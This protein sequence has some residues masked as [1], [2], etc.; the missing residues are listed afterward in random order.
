MIG[1]LWPEQHHSGYMHIF[2]PV[3]MRLQLQTVAGPPED[4]TVTCGGVG[5]GGLDD[6]SNH[7]ING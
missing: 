6:H 2:S 3:L 1:Q 5:D 4:G 7:L